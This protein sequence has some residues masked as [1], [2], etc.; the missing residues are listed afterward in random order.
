MH[1]LN[2]TERLRYGTNSITR[3]PQLRYGTVAIW[4]SVNGTEFGKCY[5]ALAVRNSANGT[6]RQR[7][8]L[9]GALNAESPQS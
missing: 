2:G 3:T 1:S 9:G 4:N 8:P 6:E 5:V 7:W